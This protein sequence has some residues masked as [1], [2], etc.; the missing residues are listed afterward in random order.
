MKIVVIANCQGEGLVSC[1]KA[2][3]SNVVADF[4][5]V[6]EIQNG[7]RSI[8]ELLNTYDFV[9]AQKF[10][11]DS[12]PLDLTHKVFYFP[13][14]AFS[15]FHPDITYLRGKKRGGTVETVESL[16]VSYHSAI[17][18]FGYLH[19]L[20]VDQILG[21]YNPFVFAQLGYI[22][23]LDESRK[24]LLEEGVNTDTPLN[25]LL[26]SW[27]QRG[28]F[29]YSFN[30]PE[31]KVIA[32]IAI[33]LM[34]K[35]KITIV[36]HNVSQFLSDPLKAMPVW[37]IYPEIAARYG[38][39][40]D[41]A[42]KRH[43]PHG[44]ID[45]RIF[46]ESSYANYANYER[47]TLEP[48]SFNVDDFN[49]KLGFSAA[50]GS[51]A[52]S[53]LQIIKSSNP[54]ANLPD[55]QFWK[56]SLVTVPMNE[57][58][59]VTTPVFRINR[60]Q[61]IATAGS[62]FAQHIARTLSRNGFNYFVTETAPEGMDEI[63]AH[64]KNYDVFSARYGN[65]YTVRQLVQLI[66]RAFD[67]YKPEDQYWIR[68][69]GRYV[70]PFRPQI[71]P[72]GFADFDAAEASRNQHFSAV[73]KMFKEMDVFVF[74][75]GLTEGWRSRHDGAVFPLAPGVAGGDMDLARYEFVNFSAEDVSRDLDKLMDHLAS[76]NSAC[77]VILTVSPVPLIATYEPRHAL[78]AT[79]YSKSVLRVA[80]EK[81]Q[82]QYLNV[83]YFPSF[84]II[85]GSYNRGAYFD[86][87]LRT[88]KDEGVAHVMRL[89]L[90]HYMADQSE[91]TP[92][93]VVT[94]IADKLID[95]KRSLFDIVCDEEAIAKF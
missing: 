78:V 19:K 18:V 29:M 84:E 71:E 66:E 85:T 54:Y 50:Q 42:F 74:T 35:A 38:M 94:Y 30:H 37:P 33:S 58:D 22:D 52:N 46:V 53:E 17:A 43:D 25:E 72:E 62:C 5:I 34:K 93:T 32:D 83:E 3:N 80:A 89:F 41:Y 11:A 87:D 88:V 81:A 4:C 45:L 59:P 9:F 27:S 10:I 57:V 44:V 79:T 90:K 95:K 24:L 49:K 23:A 28:C 65:L 40:G 20:S 77:K 48:L 16:M 91:Q 86:D 67:I 69:D 26:S 2:M 7:T 39:K 75:L 68:K 14:I 56:K 63:A 36:N 76:I 13:S 60:H 61:K 70:D 82:K 55:F 92:A 64:S 47:E 1:L 6:T 15:A 73:R 21:F 12:V 31:L 8:L 51:T